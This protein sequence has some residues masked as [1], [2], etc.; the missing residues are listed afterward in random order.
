MR[1]LYLR[2][3]SSEM[4]LHATRLALGVSPRRLAAWRILTGVLKTEN[5]ANPLR[6]QSLT[7]NES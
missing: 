5:P 6:I 1:A 7:P 2:P 3:V 4:L